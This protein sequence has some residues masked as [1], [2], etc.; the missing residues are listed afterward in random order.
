MKEQWRKLQHATSKQTHLMEHAF[1]KCLIFVFVN[2][3]GLITFLMV[4]V[5]SYY[6]SVFQSS[7]NLL[8]FPN[9]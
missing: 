1:F 6:V 4:S 7:V 3:L 9:L 2:A 8:W 5:Y